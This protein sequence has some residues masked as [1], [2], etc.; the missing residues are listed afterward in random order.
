MEMPQPTEAHAWLEKLAGSWTGTEI[1]SPSPW[2]QKGGTAKGFVENRMALGGFS[3]IQDYRQERE[4]QVTFEGHGVFTYDGERDEYVLHWFDSMGTGVNEFR[5]QREGDHL[6]LEHSGPQ[7]HSRCVFD[8]RQEG[9]Y[10]FRMQF[11]P[12]GSVWMNF[13][14]GSYTK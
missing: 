1:L 10:A 13:M 2:D 11:S 14:E 3:L 8:L 9:T 6:S 5:G 12:D 4:G 7:G